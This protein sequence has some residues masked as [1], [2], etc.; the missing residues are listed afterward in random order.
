MNLIDPAAIDAYIEG[1]LPS[2]TKA[3]GL[4]RLAL[5]KVLRRRE[6]NMQEVHVG[7][8]ICGSRR[9]AGFRAA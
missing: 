3:A 6:A 8:S 9:T 7:F 1:F 2:D 5:G 4:L